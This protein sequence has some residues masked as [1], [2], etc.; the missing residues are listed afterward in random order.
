M[1]AHA[2]HGGNERATRI[3]R[4]SLVVT[5]AYIVL[6][7]IAGIRSHSLALQPKL[8][9]LGELRRDGLVDIRVAIDPVT[10]ADDERGAG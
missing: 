5:L 6:L 7:V 3:L 4:F 2:S 9:L 8:E 1:H 10:A